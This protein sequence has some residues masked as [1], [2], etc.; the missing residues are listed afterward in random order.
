M[1]VISIGLLA[2][3]AACGPP[4]LSD[5]VLETRTAAFM[6][7]DQDDMHEHADELLTRAKIE[8]HEP[9]RQE[10]VRQLGF[11]RAP[12]TLPFLIESLH[13]DDSQQALESLAFYGPDGCDAI[14]K[15]WVGH[16]DFSYRQQMD[17]S[18]FLTTKA[19]HCLPSFKP[20]SE[21]H[22]VKL[23]RIEKGL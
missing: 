4:A 6:L 21:T 22:R 1:R 15:H 7:L 12:Q 13:G 11:A 5:D 19:R 8:P 17:Y 14:A 2:S 10:I 23:D 18:I 16:N 20:Y 3:L 9:L